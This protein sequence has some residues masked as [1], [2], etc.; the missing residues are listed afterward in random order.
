MSTETVDPTLADFPR[1][2]D[3]VIERFAALPAA[4]IADA[5]DR[6]GALDSAIQAV[7]DGAHLAGS[8]LTV[9][10]RE[11]DNLAIDQAL[12]IAHPGDVILVNSYG[13]EQRA[14]LGDIIGAQAKKRGVAGFVLD[15]ACRDREGLA[16]IGMPVFARALTPAG[17]YKTGP[18]RVGQIVACGG[19]AVA[20]GDI[21]VGDADGVVVIPLAD[22]E[23]VLAAGEAKRDTEALW[24]EEIEAGK[25]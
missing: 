22:A 21:V 16:E 4:N 1:A 13:Y 2:S 18:G 24:R 11:G 8:A 5:M 17:P 23:R 9:W 12:E 15:G 10:S 19:V 25:R 3:E 7:W 14:L 6:F 20:P